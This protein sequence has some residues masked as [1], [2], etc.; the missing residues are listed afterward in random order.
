MLMAAGDL[1]SVHVSAASLHIYVPWM[2]VMQVCAV[3][4]CPNPVI[5]AGIVHYCCM[6]V[7][8]NQ[9]SNGMHV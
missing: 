1:L 7:V 5:H 9:A 2:F 4:G 8:H 3:R 6:C